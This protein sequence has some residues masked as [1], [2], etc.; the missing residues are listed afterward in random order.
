MRDSR[1]DFL[2]FHVKHSLIHFTRSASL[3]RMGMS[4]K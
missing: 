4:G 1:D 2:L 3:M